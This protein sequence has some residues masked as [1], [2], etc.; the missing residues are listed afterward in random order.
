MICSVCR[1]QMT[2]QSIG[3]R[4]SAIGAVLSPGERTKAKVVG[5]CH[6]LRGDSLFPNSGNSVCG[7]LLHLMV[8]NLHIQVNLYRECWVRVRHCTN[9][10]KEHYK[11]MWYKL[12]QRYT[13][14]GSQTT[15]KVKIWLRNGHPVTSDL[16]TKVFKMLGTCS[17]VLFHTYQSISTSHRASQNQLGPSKKSLTRKQSWAA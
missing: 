3:K 16:I 9:W 6:C 2:E 13:Q 7:F 10:D 8:L 12:C 15:W 1:D 4:A 14:V 17:S 5:C 11:T